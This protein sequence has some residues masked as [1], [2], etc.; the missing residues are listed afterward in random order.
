MGD[1]W[2]WLIALYGH[3]TE[4]KG[5]VQQ[6]YCRY[7]EGSQTY[8]VSHVSGLLLISCVIV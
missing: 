7:D 3:F 5:R 2:W 4:H 6:Q 8:E 1:R